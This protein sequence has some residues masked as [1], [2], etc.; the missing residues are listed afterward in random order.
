M[1]NTS[2]K[3]PTSHGLSVLRYVIWLIAER[4]PLLFI[5]VPG[6]ILILFGIFLGIITLQNYNQT[7]VFLIPY[8]LICSIFLII[9]ALAM[10]I[11]LMLN[12]LPHI[13]R[14]TVLD[15]SQIR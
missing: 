4:R 5:C 9:G 3:D 10:F 1:K 2:T 6:F 11:G 7:G 12:V 13:I 14:Q 15:D 8:A